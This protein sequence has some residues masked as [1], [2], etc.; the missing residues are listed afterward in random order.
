M[1]RIPEEPLSSAPQRELAE[2]VYHR[3]D[4]SA[5]GR[6]NSQLSG[7]RDRQEDC[8]EFVKKPYAEAVDNS[9]VDSMDEDDL[10]EASLKKQRSKFRVWLE[11]II[12]P[13]GVI[14]SS[15]TLGSSTLGAGIL[16][17]PAAFNSMGLVTALLVLI[18]VTVL[19]IYSMW[20]LARCADAT[21]VRTYEDV[22]RLLLGRGADYAAAI[23]ML[24]FCLGGAVSYI[25]SIGDLL[26]PIFDDPSVP[27]FLRKKNG[28]RLITSMVWLVCILP[29]CLP[30]NIDTLRHSSIIGVI[31]VV[32]FVI[33]IVQD[34]SAFMSKNGWHKDIK[35]FNTGNGAIEGLGTVMFACLVQINAQEVYYEMAKPTP[36]NM[37]RNSTIAMSG[38]GL[39]Y[40][41]AGVFGCARF[42]T[43]VKSS[44]LLKY[45][46]RE[47]PQFWVAYC[48]IVLK[49][50]VAFALHQL[51]MRDGIYHFFSWDVYRMPWWRNAVICG[52][53]AAAVLVIGLVVPDINTVLGL[54]GSLCGGF[55]GFIFP[56][57]M[58][59]YAGNWNLKKV[60]WIEWSLTYILLFVGIIAVVFGTSASIYGVI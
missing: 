55:I 42:G 23:F 57:L 30:K 47:A 13:G 1:S 36:R 56:A 10:E 28:N 59:M 27:E 11:K 52:G 51:P 25:I 45:Q 5:N 48:G 18:V 33:C 7:A 12:P 38:C 53:I 29:L 49:I 22:A 21:R 2:P 58:I 15:F 31:M 16:G 35:F 54:V 60:G 14:A 24:G 8:T 44:I 39:L 46:P 32:F 43:T 34:S 19:T 41:L 40:V 4:D 50:C 26:T 37:L 20:L 17:L 3:E 6:P 9:A